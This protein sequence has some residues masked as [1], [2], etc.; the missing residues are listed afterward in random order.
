MPTPDPSSDSATAALINDQMNYL[1]ATYARPMPMFVKGDGCYLWDLENRRYLD[2]T[3]GIAVTSLGHSDPEMSRILAQQVY[4]YF[5]DQAEIHSKADLLAIV[6]DGHP[7][8]QPLSPALGRLS[9]KATGDQDRRNRGDAQREQSVC[10][11]FW[12]R[13][14]R[15]RAQIRS[16]SRKGVTTRWI[17]VRDRVL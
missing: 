3:A 4:L 16:K 13:S 1:V 11:Q 17:K 5:T 8:L 10:V 6:E 9:F 12:D 7:H 15:S 14:E 2:M